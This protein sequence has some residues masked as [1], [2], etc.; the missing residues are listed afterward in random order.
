MGAGWPRGALRLPGAS[1]GAEQRQHLPQECSDGV[2]Q[3]ARDRQPQAESTSESP[4]ALHKQVLFLRGRQGR[5]GE[6]KTQL[7]Y[8]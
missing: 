6:I 8:G 2:G 1:C 4:C 5:A 3:T 7:I